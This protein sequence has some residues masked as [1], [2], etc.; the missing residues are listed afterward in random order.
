MAGQKI[1]TTWRQRKQ[2]CQNRL[3][4]WCAACKS[5]A[6]RDPLR[7]HAIVA[8]KLLAEIDATIIPDDH[9]AAILA[10]RLAEGKR[11]FLAPWLNAPIQKGARNWYETRQSRRAEAERLAQPPRPKPTTAQED[12]ADDP[13][14]ELTAAEIAT[15]QHARRDRQH[16][17]AAQV[18]AKKEQ[19]KRLRNT[20]EGN[21]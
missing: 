4:K 10:R 2:D 7:F 16:D 18:L 17:L 20:H 19:Q 13:P 12:F 5:E 11:E 14:P 6:G 8:P 1:P 21:E 9:D 15:K 3:E